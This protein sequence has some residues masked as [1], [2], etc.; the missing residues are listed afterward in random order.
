MDMNLAGRTMLITGGRTSG[1]NE[2]RYRHRHL[3]GPRSDSDGRL[4][5]HEL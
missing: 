5:T 4:E 2:L 3:H 1:P